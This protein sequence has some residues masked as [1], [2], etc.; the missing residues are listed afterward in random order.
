MFMRLDFGTNETCSIGSGFSAPLPWYLA[1]YNAYMWLQRRITKAFS[2]HLRRL[3][4]CR[5]YYAI[6]NPVDL[7]DWYR[8]EV[9]VIVTSSLKIEYPISIPSNVIAC[10]PI[11]TPVPPPS[12]LEQLWQDCCYK[13]SHNCRRRIVLIDLQ[14]LTETEAREIVQSVL[15]ILLE[16]DHIQ[17]LWNIKNHT[18]IPQNDEVHSIVDAISH[19]SHNRTRKLQLDPSETASLLASDTIS[20]IVHRGE[21]G[22]FHDALT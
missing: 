22:L 16:D 19:I 5:R 4:L 13:C 14:H 8:D 9:A 1:P 6:A 11:S 10:G 15:A 12:N 2:S 21:T 18:E 20:F 17:V 3:N 7:V